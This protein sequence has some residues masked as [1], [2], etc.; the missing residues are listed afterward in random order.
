MGDD[1]IG[2][3]LSRRVPGSTRSGPSQSVRRDLSDTDVHRIQA[4]IDAEHAGADMP[5]PREPNTEPIPVVTDS[6]PGNNQVVNLPGT[7]E[8]AGKPPRAARA[9]RA[10]EPL[11]AVAALRAAAELR[12]A[13]K[14]RAAKSHGTEEP[15]SAAGRLLPEQSVLTQEPVIAPV[16]APAPEPL[17]AEMPMRAPEPVRA[18]E[19]V[20]APEPGIA[21]VPAPAPVPVRAEEPVRA[22]ER[23][24]AQQP[25]IAAEPARRAAPPRAT[26]PPTEPSPG[27]IGWLWPEE[28]AGRGGGGGYRPPGRWNGS[29]RW[30]Y[31]TATMVAAGAVVLAAGGLVVGMSLR[32]TPVAVGQ[33]KGVASAPAGKGSSTPTTAPSHAASSSATPRL[34]AGAI[35]RASNWVARQASADVSVACTAQ[36]CPAL[37]A[38]GLPAS[39]EVRL[40][41]AQ[42]L[43]NAKIVVVTPALRLLLS[44]V[45]PSVVAP[46]VLA[47][48]GSGSAEITIQPVYPGGGAAYQ[49]A[50]R[51]DVQTRIRVGEQLLNSGRVT[52]MPMA[53]SALAEGRV[54]PRL[55]HVLEA[56]TSQQPIDI[57]S[58][59]NSGP[60]AG[61]GIPFRTVELA[62]TDSSSS[63][64]GSAYVQWM[65]SVVLR[66]STA[67]P[68][69]NHPRL[70]TLPDGERVAVLEY[71][72]DPPVLVSG[73]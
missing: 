53:Q 34:H 38:A 59:S 4:A 15:W 58:F 51:Q 61:P 27:T 48:F 6:G 44:T 40:T 22:P 16:P 18:E 14:P 5:G 30:R 23:V 10:E 47:S 26:W 29:G 42:S 41:N 9:P 7:T 68:A 8:R 55:L 24:N 63:L 36:I 12:A 52:G 33:G 2:A 17:R 50:L 25:M 46:V 43:S 45:R 1:G 69:I 32:G 28:A 19:S 64:I 39:R 20:H 73:R 21:P 56:L 67:F 60:G 54:D 3:P 71:P 62:T 72:L 57:V 65:G 66:P 35:I 37:I 31:R 70:A 11:R 13:E 49:A